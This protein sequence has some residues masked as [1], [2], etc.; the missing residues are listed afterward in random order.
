MSSFNGECEKHEQLAIDIATIKS[1]IEYI[2]EAITKHIDVE[3][4]PGGYRNQLILLKNEVDV[5][6]KGYWKAC[7]ISGVIGGLLGQVSPSIFNWFAGIVLA[8]H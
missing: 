7:I 5:I 2:K 8:S 3:E 6:K 1:N 4:R